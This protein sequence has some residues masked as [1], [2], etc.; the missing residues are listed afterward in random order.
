MQNLCYSNVFNLGV[1]YS[2]S[3]LFLLKEEKKELD[4]ILAKRSKSSKQTEEKTADEKTTLHSKK[5]YIHTFN[6]H[7]FK[8]QLLNKHFTVKFFFQQF[9]LL[10]IKSF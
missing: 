9:I 1:V 6:E 5:T 8:H 4:E 2:V 3:I 7:N 10:K